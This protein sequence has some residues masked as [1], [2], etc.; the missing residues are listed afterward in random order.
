[1]RTIVK[2]SVVG[3]LWIAGTLPPLCAQDPMR[4]HWTGSVEL[5]NQT[6]GME[7]DLDKKPNGWVGSIAIPAQNASG[8]P[9]DAITF[10]AGKCSFRMK[11]APGAPTFE[12]SLSADGKTMTG[13]LTQ[14]PGSFPFKFTRAGDP[15]VDEAKASPALAAPFLGTWEG[16]L[17]EPNLRL[18]LKMSND[19]GGAQAV[20]IS[21]DQGGA[22]IP[23]TTIEQKDTKLTLTVN[24]VGGKYEAE[25]NK[26]GTELTGTWSQG[27]G[28]LPLK[29]KKAAAPD[30]KP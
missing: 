17:D 30:K 5:P 21:V 25:I 22:E 12:G 4:G 19:A 16:K 27:G 8:I 23:V 15:K 20:L 18:V 13:N 29:L 7:V 26:E 1:M 6:L 14:G 24:M 2:G 10:N 3:L 11:G 9:L 28:N